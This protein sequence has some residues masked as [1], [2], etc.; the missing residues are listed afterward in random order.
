[1]I[2]MDASTDGPWPGP[3]FPVERERERSS[4]REIERERERERE[5]PL[6][7][8]IKK[9]I[10]ACRAQKLKAALNS[11]LHLFVFNDL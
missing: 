1:M 7:L 11:E 4:L 9:S 6:S 5:L 10:S 2:G 8:V 3:V